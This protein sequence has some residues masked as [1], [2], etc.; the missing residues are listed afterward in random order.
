MPVEV[1]NFL[2]LSCKLR[3]L[4]GASVRATQHGYNRRAR[5]PAVVMPSAGL[6]RAAS[7]Y[8]LHSN[9]HQCGAVSRSHSKDEQHRPGAHVAQL[10]GQLGGLQRADA[11]SQREKAAQRAQPP[12]QRLREGA[13][14]PLP[15]RLPLQTQRVRPGADPQRHPQRAQQAATS[16]HAATGHP[17]L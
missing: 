2:A 5:P 7:P 12:A 10:L 8:C 6:T 9:P 15:Q 17:P 13:V 14:H 1:A 3:V 11:V 4:S 16:A